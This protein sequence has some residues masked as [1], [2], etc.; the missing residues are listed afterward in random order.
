VWSLCVRSVASSLLDQLA[1]CVIVTG[2]RTG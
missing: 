2:L 1:D